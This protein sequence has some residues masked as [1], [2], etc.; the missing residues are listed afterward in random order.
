[1]NNLLIGNGLNNRLNINEL[2][3][4]R[5]FSRFQKNIERYSPI[6]Q[7]LFSVEIN[8]C[9]AQMICGNNHKENIE[10]LAKNLHQYIINKSKFEDKNN[11]D[12]LRT[13]IKNIGILSIFFDNNG[14]ISLVY[15]VSKMINI[16]KYDNV[17]SLNYMEVW[18]DKKRA[19]YL[20]GEVGLGSLPDIR[21]M[22]LIEESLLI[23]PQ[24]KSAVEEMDRND[25]LG[26]K[27]NSHGI[28]MTP[29]D[30]EKKDLTEVTG[31]LPGED[32]FPAVDLYP[33]DKQPLYE[34]LSEIDSLDIYG[35]SPQGDRSLIEKI[36]TIPK[37][38]V[39]VRD[40][41][42]K[43]AK[44]WEKQLKDCIFQVKSVEEF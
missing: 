8:E 3:N 1:M 12:R 20:H 35:V 2:S 30:V 4:E 13:I 34:K 28:I 26:I 33:K 15:D 36:R 25:N 6:F 39:F 21:N 9:V 7:A 41:N 27:I 44:E 5:I 17:F 42:G 40:L 22:Y 43:T 10:G 11:E 31:L 23:N 18:D 32:L 29:E 19:I 37:V 38:T 14:K 16:D 24:Y